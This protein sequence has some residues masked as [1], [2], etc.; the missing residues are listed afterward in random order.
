MQCL[1][2]RNLCRKPKSLKIKTV[3]F[4]STTNRFHQIISKKSQNNNIISIE[5]TKKYQ[6]YFSY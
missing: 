4:F 3:D 6:Y 2:F 1:I 5:K